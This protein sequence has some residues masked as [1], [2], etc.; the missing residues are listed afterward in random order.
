MYEP[1][2]YLERCL[3]HCL[4]ITPN[5]HC[6]QQMHVPLVRAVRLLVLLIWYQGLRRPGL[7]R[8]FWWQLLQMARQQPRLLALYLGLCATGEHFFEYRQLARERIGDQLGQDP[9]VP[10][11]PAPDVSVREAVLVGA[12]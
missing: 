9:L 1:A 3:R 5:P 8:Q 10:S 12:D 6:S 11:P 4:A 2:T 7:R